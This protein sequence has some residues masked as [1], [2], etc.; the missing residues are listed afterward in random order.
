MA[1]L[2]ACLAEFS[3]DKLPSGIKITVSCRNATEEAV[4]TEILTEL[5]ATVRSCSCSCSCS[6]VYRFSLLMR[7]TRCWKCIKHGLDW[8]PSGGPDLIIDDNGNAVSFI[9]WCV[10][11]EEIYA[12]K[13]GLPELSSDYAETQDC[14]SIIGEGLETDPK[15]Y[16]NLKKGLCGVSVGTANDLEQLMLKKSY[17]SLSFP[18]FNICDFVTLTKYRK[19]YGG[20]CPILGGIKR[21]SNMTISGKIALVCGY[22]HASQECAMALKQGGAD[23]FVAEAD[24][25]RARQAFQDGFWVNKAPDRVVSEADILV[26]NFNMYNIDELRNVKNMKKNAVIYN[27][28]PILDHNS[29]IPVALFK[30]YF[31]NKCVIVVSNPGYPNLMPSWSAP[32]HVVTMRESM[33]RKET[34]KYVGE[35]TAKKETEG[36]AA[37]EPVSV[38]SQK[39][40]NPFPP[41]TADEMS[42]SKMLIMLIQVVPII[43]ALA[44]ALS[45]VSK[46]ELSFSAIWGGDKTKSTE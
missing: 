37:D 38:P 22:D 12:E 39:R 26:A 30:P 45:K 28:G 24:P 14:L 21:G 43:G 10:I 7:E 25:D 13:G 29:S 41:T 1:G 42:M 27:T 18:V 36:Q 44:Y 6:L 19:M 34:G 16:H 4:L 46:A 5:G 9:S 33:G 17:R 35:L 8:G 11:A 40:T 2:K 20:R 31:A 3:P 23:V 32:S 15:R